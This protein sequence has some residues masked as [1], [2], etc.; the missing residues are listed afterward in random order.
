VVCALLSGL[1][2]GC[3]SPGAESYMSRPRC[4][5]RDARSSPMEYSSPQ[6]ARSTSERCSCRSRIGASG[7]AH[8]G[9]HKYAR[10]SDLSFVHA[11]PNAMH[12][13]K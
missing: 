2:F 4:M 7:I 12:A 1:G 6:D 13:A 5:Q 10:I 3:W 8:I 11:A 9:T